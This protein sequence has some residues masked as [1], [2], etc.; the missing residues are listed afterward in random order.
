MS[1]EPSW[2]QAEKTMGPP[3]FQQLA[4]AN[5]AEGEDNTTPPHTKRCGF[6]LSPAE[7]AVSVKHR[8]PL[9]LYMLL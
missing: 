6:S 3:A 4:G 7:G 1:E 9:T 2:L 8:A 5:Q